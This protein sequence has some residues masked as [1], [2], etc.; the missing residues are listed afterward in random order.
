MDSRTREAQNH[1]QEAHDYM[2]DGMSSYKWQQAYGHLCSALSLLTSEPEPC[3]DARELLGAM[4]RTIRELGYREPPLTLLKETSGACVQLIAAY[5][6]RLVQ[7]ARADERAIVEREVAAKLSDPVAVY[8]NALRGT[9]DVSEVRAD[10]RRRCAERATKCIRQPMEPVGIEGI[11]DGL[12]RA[13]LQGTEP[14]RPNDLLVEAHALLSIIPECRDSEWENDRIA[15][16]RRIEAEGLQGTEPAKYVES[17]ADR[18]ERLALKQELG[19]GCHDEMRYDEPTKVSED[20]DMDEGPMHDEA[21]RSFDEYGS[22]PRD[23]S[24]VCP[25]YGQGDKA[26]KAASYIDG[27]IKCRLVSR[28]KDGNRG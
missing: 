20:V 17:E 5:A 25:K 26:L 1:V 24:D 22:I 18:D 28:I 3:E 13:I 23:Y 21:E 14:L 12:E 10:E 11:C 15:I 27:Y 16:A 8:A 19:A 7:E 6:S 2:T 9:I 4:F